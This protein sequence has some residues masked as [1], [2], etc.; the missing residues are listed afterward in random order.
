MAQGIESFIGKA[1]NR[2]IR[3]LISVAVAISIVA[4]SLTSCD[5]IAVWSAPE[6][7]R[8][9]ARSEAA[10]K[11]DELFWHTFHQG[12]YDKIQS[13]LEALTAAYLATPTDAVTA[14]HIAWLH[15]WR[16]A[17]RARLTVAPA[18]ITDDIHLAR[19]YFHEAVKLDPSDVRT[20]GFLAG[21][22]VIEGT[23]HQ[24]EKLTREG[25]FLLRDAI[26][27]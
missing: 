10:Q 17:E 11:A 6:K 12:E 8:A 2:K 15:N 1:A 14:A 3:L 9:Q 20:L 21:H 16:A 22:I 7:Q 25:Y 27:A 18:T 26:K 19:R 4:A 23:L 13:S 24:D 5:R